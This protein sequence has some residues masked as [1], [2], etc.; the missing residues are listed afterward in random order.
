MSYYQ[1]LSE[2]DYYR[3][4]GAK[5][6]AVGWLDIG[7][8]YTSGDV[9]AA[10]FESLLTLLVNPWQPAATAGRHRCPFCRFSGGPSTV[11][12]GD[13]AAYVGASNLLV[14]YR[15]C[16]FVAPSLIAH[17]IDAHGYCP[18]ADFQR[19]V[20]E[21]PPMRSMAYL[22]QLRVHGVHKLGTA[23]M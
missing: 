10:F 14:P 9:T 21:C 4:D 11:S 17:Y 1:D 15:D 22:K 2:F 16:V 8:P 6:L 18:P 7:T 13:T 19:A 12:Y 3:L 20:A 23:R 5:L